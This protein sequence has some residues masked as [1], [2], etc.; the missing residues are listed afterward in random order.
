[1]LPVSHG[2]FTSCEGKG[3]QRGRYENHRHC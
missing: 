3:R 2:D 1:V